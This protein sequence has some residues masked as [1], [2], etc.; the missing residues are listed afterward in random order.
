MIRD[1]LQFERLIAELR[2]DIELLRALEEK[3]RRALDRV[4]KGAVDELDW[5]ALAYTIHNAYNAI[6]NYCL[7]ITKFFENELETSS[8]HRDLVRRMMIEI[9]E[10]RPALFDRGLAERVDELRGFRHRF[11]NM[12]G[13]DLDPERVRLVQ[14]RLPATLSEFYRAHE[15]FIEKLRLIQDSL[16]E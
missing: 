15:A 4:D 1:R 11:R 6:E 7:R 2:H 10:L 13:S 8:W 3:N 16:E 5:A 12:Y 9:P 14:S